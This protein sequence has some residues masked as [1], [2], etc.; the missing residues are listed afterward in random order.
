MQLPAAD[1]NAAE[2]EPAF[3]LLEN[4]PQGF[5]SLAIKTGRLLGLI[6]SLFDIGSDDPGIAETAIAGK[7]K[8]DNGAASMT[9]RS[10]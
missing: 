3:G 5:R 7:R 10:G 6:V 4:T 2:F 8:A 9:S 1:G